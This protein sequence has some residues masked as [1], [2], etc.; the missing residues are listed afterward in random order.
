MITE[1]KIM[2]FDMD[3]ITDK[4]YLG[5]YWGAYEKDF[6]KLLNI[7]GILVCADLKAFYPQDFEYKTIKIK[8]TKEENIFDHFYDCFDFIDKHEKIFIHCQF[9][10]SRS[11]SIVIGYIMWKDKKTFKEAL[12][13]VKK[14]RRVVSPN[15]GFVEQLLRLE[16]EIIYN[17]K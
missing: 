9:G 17:S 15:E 6:M 2:K 5:D 8:D 10:V 7:T 3:Q 1:N 12:E 13:F 16:S 4:I 11:A 14:K